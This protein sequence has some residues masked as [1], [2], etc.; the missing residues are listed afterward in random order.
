MDYYE[1]RVRTDAGI[2]G[3]LIAFFSELPFD[4]FEEMEN[5]FKAYMPASLYTDEVGKYLNDL[6]DRFEFTFDFT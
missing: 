2:S 5:G 1:F 6:K 4:T 3:I